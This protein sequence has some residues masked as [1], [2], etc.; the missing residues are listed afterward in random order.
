VSQSI[1][2][3]QNTVSN[4]M[5]KKAKKNTLL[6]QFQNPIEKLRN[7]GKNDTPN[8]NTLPPT[9]LACLN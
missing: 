4:K 2:V 3:N 1:Q 5:K 9:L 7:R 8:T 6:E